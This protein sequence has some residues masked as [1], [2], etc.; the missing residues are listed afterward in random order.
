MHTN[1]YKIIE[2]STPRLNDRTFTVTR[3]HVVMFEQNTSP[4]TMFPHWCWHL[5]CMNCF[6][7]FFFKYSLRREL[8]RC[9]LFCIFSLACFVWLYSTV[10]I[11]EWHLVFDVYVTLGRKKGRSWLEAFLPC[12]WSCRAR[13]FMDELDHVASPTVAC[14]SVVL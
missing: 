14:R 13:A 10:A 6:F 7:F 12:S 11:R 5:V 9:F 1:P 2:E 8:Y 3:E 4:F